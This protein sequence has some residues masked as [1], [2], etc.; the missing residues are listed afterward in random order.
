MENRRVS[1]RQ[2]VGGVTAGATAGVVSSG[3]PAAAAA[4]SGPVFSAR[5]PT[6]HHTRVLAYS[7]LQGRGGG[8]KL[9][10][11]EV[12][13]RW[14]LYMGHLWHRGWSILDVTDPTR[15]RVVNF[16]PGPANTWTIQMEVNAGKMV[17]ALERIAPGWGGDPAAPFDEGVIIWDLTADP[18][19][20]R[21]LGQFR[22]GGTGTH[23]NLYAGGRYVHLAAGMPGYSG[24]IYVIIDIADPTRPVE[25]GRWWVPGQHVAGGETPEPSVSLHGPPYVEGTLAYL[26]YGAAGMVVVDISDPARPRFVS[27]LDFSPPFNPNIGGHSVLPLPGRRLALVTSEAIR[28]RCDEP[29]NHTSVVDVADP[30]RPVLLST[31]PVPEPPRR[32]PFGSFCERGGRFGP[33]NFHQNYHSPYTDHTETLVYLTFFN[34]GLRIYDISDPRDPNEVGYFIPPDPTRRFGPQPPDA[35]VVQSEDVLV[36]ARGVVYLSNKNQGLW[37]L[38]YTGRR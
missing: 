19:R 23:R 10:I 34:A 26:P 3:G 1:R 27:Q 15:P 24:N 37:I 11:Q 14:L 16:I 22:T 25:T 9:A 5:R 32:A 35:L 30:A 29:L 36:D 4:E 17:T 18:V 8:F 28:S 21:R 6:A 2:F 7:D 31:F 38:R 12:G 20:P 33:H 13:G